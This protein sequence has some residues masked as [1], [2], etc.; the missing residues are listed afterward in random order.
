MIHFY[1]LRAF[2]SFMLLFRIYLILYN[3]VL[4]R[5][6]PNV[7]VFEHVCEAYLL[8]FDHSMLVLSQLGQYKGEKPILCT[9]Q[10]V[11]WLYFRCS[12]ITKVHDLILGSR[13]SVRMAHRRGRLLLLHATAA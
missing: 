13:S 12:A 1:K 4:L 11:K 9:G 10:E 3:F 7:G 6:V 5:V 2:I 8:P